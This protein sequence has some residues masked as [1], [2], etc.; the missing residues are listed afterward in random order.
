MESCLRI[1]QYDE[2]INALADRFNGSSCL[3]IGLHRGST[4]KPSPDLY[5]P[6]QATLHIG[7]IQSIKLI[8]CTIK[9]SLSTT[10]KRRCAIAEELHWWHCPPSNTNIYSQRLALTTRQGINIYEHEGKGSILTSIVA[11]IQ[12]EPRSQATVCRDHEEMRMFS[13][14]H[15]APEAKASR[16]GA[17][18]AERQEA[19]K[20]SCGDRSRCGRSSR[21]MCMRTQ[22][23][24]AL[25]AAQRYR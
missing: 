5:P 18:R 15:S 12:T 2:H 11:S 22:A 21:R 23:P 16:R 24:L 8:I 3:P 14:R 1:E 9:I 19:R 10:D 6:R 13:L 17:R 20:G 25:H 4:R 7:Q